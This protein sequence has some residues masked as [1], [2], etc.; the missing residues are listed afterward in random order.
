MKRFLHKL[1]VGFLSFTGKEAKSA[2]K[3]FYHTIG[4]TDPTD[5]VLTE[6][7]LCDILTKIREEV[8]K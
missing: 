6:K 4:K 3:T 2:G 1:Y 7:E 8:T 5:T